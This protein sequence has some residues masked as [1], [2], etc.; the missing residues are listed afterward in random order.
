MIPRLNC[1]CTVNPERLGRT[2]I[3]HSVGGE[4]RWHPHLLV[5]LMCS[6]SP[7]FIPGVWHEGDW[8]KRDLAQPNYGRLEHASPITGWFIAFINEKFI[9]LI[10]MCKCTDICM[11]F[12]G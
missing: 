10:S 7:T 12:D 11:D 6:M 9:P 4:L 5:F 1:V 8:L 3:T 2:Q